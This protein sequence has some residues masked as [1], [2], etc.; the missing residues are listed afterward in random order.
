MSRKENVLMSCNRNYSLI[1]IF[2][3]INWLYTYTWKYIAALY[4]VRTHDYISVSVSSY[5]W[6]PWS[7]AHIWHK[8]QKISH[9]LLDVAQQPLT[10]LWFCKQTHRF[11]SDISWHSISAVF[12]QMEK[13][14][15]PPMAAVSWCCCCCWCWVNVRRMTVC[16]RESELRAQ[17]VATHIRAAIITDIAPIIIRLISAVSIRSLRGSCSL[18]RL[19]SLVH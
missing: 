2:H 3:S 11:S 16:P 15:S 5:R 18:A 14:A 1:L 10:R 7:G 8:Q 6:N 9:L 13:K 19:W 12:P 17:G 4:N